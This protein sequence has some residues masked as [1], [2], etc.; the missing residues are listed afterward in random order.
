MEQILSTV[1]IDPALNVCTA[2]S[3]YRRDR[4]APYTERERRLKQS[5][6]P[7]LIEAWNFN[8]LLYIS[9]EA[10]F[11]GKYSG[12]RALID[13]TGMLYN[14]EPGFAE[15]IRMEFPEWRGPYLPDTLTNAFLNN[16]GG[17]YKG[18]TLSADI[19]YRAGQDRLLIGIRTATRI[20]RLSA[21]ELM[22]AREFAAGK[23]HKE[24]AQVMGVSPATV[25]N[26][27]RSVYAKLG[28][29][30]KIDLAKLLKDM[31]SIGLNQ[32]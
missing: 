30:S 9:H 25:R 7:H 17:S 27:I 19:L 12:S 18:N 29:S 10:G 22:V 20:H 15:T 23:T 3:L 32:V 13:R 31:D 8:T 6:M 5:I 28:V 11:T 21:R 24:I 4:K 16:A 2:V 26:Q 14:A 1:V